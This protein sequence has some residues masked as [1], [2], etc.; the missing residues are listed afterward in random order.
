MRNVSDKVVEKMKRQFMYRNLLHENRA[1]CVIMWTNSIEPG[2]PEMTLLIGCMR[3]ACWVAKATSIR[4]CSTYCL[5]TT[6]MVTR[7][8]VSVTMYVH[9]L[10]C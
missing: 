5:F 6:A 2:R 9:S 4:I 10:S 1:V 3:V 8:C 7:M